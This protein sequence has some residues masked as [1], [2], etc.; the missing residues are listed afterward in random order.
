MIPTKATVIV[1]SATGTSRK[2][3]MA[4]AKGLGCP[5]DV[6]DVTAFADALQAKTFGPE[7]IVIF[8]AP[9]YSGRIPKIAMPRLSAFKGEGTPCIVTTAY[10][11]RDFDDALV[12]LCDMAKDNG[13]IPVGAAA[14][15]AQHTFGTIAVG[16]PN[17]EDLTEDE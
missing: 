10:G 9:C 2:S 12:E 13:F 7:E 8:G 14:L 5:V 11:N 15:V 16:R 3:A 1:F 6:I 17:S 4:I